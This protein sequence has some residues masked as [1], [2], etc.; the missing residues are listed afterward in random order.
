MSIRF[1]CL[2]VDCQQHLECYCVEDGAFVPFVA[3]LKENE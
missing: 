2:L 1:V 3:S